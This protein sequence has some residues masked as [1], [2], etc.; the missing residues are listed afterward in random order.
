MPARVS[1]EG[2]KGVV[3]VRRFPLASGASFLLALHDP[4][5]KDHWTNESR[6]LTILNKS[7]QSFISSPKYNVRESGAVLVQMRRLGSEMCECG[8]RKIRLS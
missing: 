8:E 2:V 6:E 7:D 5:P 3:S 1:L 4:K